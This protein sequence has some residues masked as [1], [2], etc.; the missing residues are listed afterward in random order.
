MMKRIIHNTA[1]FACLSFFILACKTEYDIFVEPKAEMELSK[2]SVDILEPVYIKNL[3]KGETFSFW[4]GDEGQD[5]S[6]IADSRNAGL[7]PNR[8]IDFEYTYLRSGTYTITMIASSFNEETGK[9]VQKVITQQ[10]TVNPGNNG[11]NFTR[12]AIDN[13]LAGY[14]PEGIIEGNKI[15]IPIGFINRVSGIS[16]QDYAVLINKRPPLFSANSSSAKVYS[17]EGTLLQGRGDDN[18]QLN[19]ID[20]N[21]LEPIIRKFTVVQDG[22]PNEYA[23]AALFYPVISDLKVLGF[24]ASEY[25]KDGLSTVS[26]DEIEKLQ[27]AYP[28]Q[29]FFGVFLVGVKP[30][31][32]KTAILDF[33]LTNGASLHLKATGEEI[34]SGTTPVDIS[35]PPV[36]FE[37]IRTLDGFSI[38]SEF[39]IYSTV[40]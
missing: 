35:E 39:K 25:S 28:G 27:L 22:L 38:T 26:E 24:T 31:Q 23:V 9:F 14:S 8:G 19:L 15:S 17:E 40:F 7:P 3:G 21:T 10:I 2:T 6:K 12:F 37:I 20:V 36:D 5:Y 29:T 33:T 18:Y 1:V 32:L 11:N 4:P 16:D 34:I 13:A 30:D